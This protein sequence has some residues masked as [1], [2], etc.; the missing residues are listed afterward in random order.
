MIH[1]RIPCSDAL[2]RKHHTLVVVFWHFEVSQVFAFYFLAI[3]PYMLPTHLKLLD[4]REVLPK[5]IV[6]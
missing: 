3:E 6:D 1:F 4:I 5:M 2:D